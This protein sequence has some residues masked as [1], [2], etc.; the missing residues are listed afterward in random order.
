MYRQKNMVGNFENVGY[1]LPGKESFYNVLMMEETQT[2]W[3][4]GAGAVSKIAAGGGGSSGWRTS[5][6]LRTTSEE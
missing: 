4:A 2:V 3:A 5:R 6:A 1:C